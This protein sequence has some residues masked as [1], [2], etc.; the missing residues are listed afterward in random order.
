MEKLSEAKLKMAH[1]RNGNLY[2]ERVYLMIS[3]STFRDKV[4][5]IRNILNTKSQYKIQ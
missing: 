3:P 1:F 5:V 4:E 2:I